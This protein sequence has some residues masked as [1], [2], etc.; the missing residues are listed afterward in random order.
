LTEP[1][2]KSGEPEH[3]RDKDNNDDPFAG[4]LKVMLPKDSWIELS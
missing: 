1:N 2:E 4:K 3:D